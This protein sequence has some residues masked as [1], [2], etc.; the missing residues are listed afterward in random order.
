MEQVKNIIF[1][2]LILMSPKLFGQQPVEVDDRVEERNFMPY[3]LMY[4]KD[5]SGAITFQQ[6]SSS[7]FV[8]KFRLHT[9]YRNKDFVPDVA[10]WVR[11]PIRHLSET[12]KVWLLEFYDQP[13]D[14]IDAYV[15][16]ED[17]SYQ[18]VQL[19]DAQ[20]FNDRLFSHKNFE[21]MLQMKSD[22]VMFYYFKIQSHEF[23]DIRIAFRSTNRFIYYALNEYFLFG[24]FYGMILIIALYNFLTFLAIPEKK[25]VYYIFYI[26]SVALYAM[27]LD[28][29][30][31]QYLWPKYPAFNA[32]ATGIS[33][34]SV[35]LW[36]LIF[37]RRFLGTKVKAPKVDNLLKWMIALRTAFFCYALFFQPTLFSQRVIEILPLSLIFYTAIRVWSRGYRPAR[38][39]VIAYG[40]LFLGFFMRALVYF[41][42]LPFTILSH[43]SLH[44]SFVLEML[45]LTLA[46][47]YC[48]ANPRHFSG[49][50]NLNWGLTASD[51]QS[52][53]SAHSPTN[54]LGVISPT[55]AIS[56]MPYTP[57]ESMDALK[58]FY[59]TMGDRLWGS[60]GFYDAFNVTE[61]WV[62]NSYLA[63]DQGPII[64]MI[65]NHRSG[66]L[67]NLFMS[68]PEVQAGLTKLGFTY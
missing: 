5:V 67:W 59:Y 60:Y 65:E 55:A 8:N 48:I 2:L 26:L 21:L 57:V 19:G 12:K 54:D 27:S 1:C 24:I 17:G 42:V 20:P 35:I 66:L 9:D 37:T 11:L 56:S 50:S 38:F 28:G 51:N 22:T 31:F 23:A 16:Q 10:Y 63:I 40:I 62:A 6:I 41:N 53:Y 14:K 52:G 18:R 64:V 58:F 4:F 32:Y 68:A 30:G 39:F 36:A 46:R 15:P 3:E 43:Y 49:Y 45:F 29:I 7:E 13:I 33:L 47:A 44:L 25:Y 34:Y 61:G